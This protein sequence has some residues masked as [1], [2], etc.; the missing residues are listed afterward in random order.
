M[1]RWGSWRC[2][3]QGRG[4]RSSSGGATGSEGPSSGSFSA[5]SQ[6]SSKIRFMSPGKR[7]Q[8]CSSSNAEA[9]VIGPGRVS[10]DVGILEF[11]FRLL[12]E[13]A[14]EAIPGDRVQL[15]QGPAETTTCS[16]LRSTAPRPDQRRHPAAVHRPDTVCQPVPSDRTETP[17]RPTSGLIRAASA[18]SPWHY[19]MGS[20]R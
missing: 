19:R 14:Q 6:R 7:N 15:R 16:K 17:Q 12:P 1:P 3:G 10:M 18:R 8:S 9:V 20:V 4:Y 13:L 11:R 5:S 2:P